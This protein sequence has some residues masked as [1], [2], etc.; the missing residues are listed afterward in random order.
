MQILLGS[1]QYS[2]ETH[3]WVWLLWHALVGYAPLHVSVL[4]VSLQS[5]RG[6]KALVVLLVDLL[7]ASG[8]LMS[9]VRDMV[10]NNPIV[11]IGTKMDLLP[12]GCNPK[13]VATWLA[14]AAGRKR[15]QVA[16]AHLVSS[17]T[18][19]GIAA[20]TAKVC[21][22]RKGRDVFVVGAANVG[23]SAFVRAMLNEMS[24]FTGGNFDAAALATS[25]FLPVESAMPGTTLGL[26]PLQAFETGGTLYDT[27]GVHLHHRIPHMLTPTELKLLHPR[28]QLTAYSPAAPLEIYRE[29]QE[30][31][32][33]D[34][35]AG[36][37]AGAGLLPYGSNRPSKPKQVSATYIWSGLVRVD[38]VSGPPSS[39]I[40]FYGPPTL[41]VYGLPLLEDGQE[42]HISVADDDHSSADEQPQPTSDQRAAAGSKTSRTSS[43]SSRVLLCKDSVKA[44][45]GLV[46]HTLVVKSPI[47]TSN[48]LADVAVSGLPGWIGV[49]A[50]FSK[51]DVVLRIWV[52][53]GVEVFL[54]P[55]LPCPTPP[56]PQGA[57]DAAGPE[58]LEVDEVLSQAELNQDWDTHRD[59]LGLGP[60]SKQD[61]EVVKMLLFGN[62]SAG[63]TGIVDIK[64][65]GEQWLEDDKAEQLGEAED[66]Q[67]VLRAEQLVHRVATSSA[68]RSSGS[69]SSRRQR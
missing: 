25:R 63:L 12:A 31:E 8:T 59:F 17:H 24:S 33:L 11:L 52:P 49:F 68:R 14:E 56:K 5:V 3:C 54:R 39:C 60:M 4:G 61:E 67:Q 43:S 41:R 53:R 36:S 21:R 15:L 58:D 29:Q 47:P 18:G 7:D 44:R 48:C 55:P 9:K 10:G 57:D 16:S 66:Q 37:A 19:E 1:A 45:G 46:P 40:V 69:G 32:Q 28:K 27:P 51:Q 35:P 30:Y 13:Q 50:P 22:E 26:I 2:W 64:D 65:E 23:K 42:F 62:G 6:V 20:V 34:R 38:I